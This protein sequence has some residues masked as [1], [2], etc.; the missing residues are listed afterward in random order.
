MHL[1]KAKRTKKI[2]YVYER[3]REHEPVIDNE[4]NNNIRGK[5]TTSEQDR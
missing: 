4:T 3:I 5:K 1:L 2:D